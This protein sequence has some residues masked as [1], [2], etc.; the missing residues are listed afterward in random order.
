[1]KIVSLAG[2]IVPSGF[3]VKRASRSRHALNVGGRT[4]EEPVT[5]PGVTQV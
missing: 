4:V 5:V 2:S 1:M 3:T